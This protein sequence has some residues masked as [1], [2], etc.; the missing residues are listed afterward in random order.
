MKET[1][2]SVIRPLGKYDVTAILKVSPAQISNVNQ[3]LDIAYFY[4]LNVDSSNIPLIT[5]KQDSCEIAGK[6]YSYKFN[7][8]KFVIQ[9]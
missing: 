9:N 3:T 5:R 1:T 2:N 6:V 7:G 8:K 4:K